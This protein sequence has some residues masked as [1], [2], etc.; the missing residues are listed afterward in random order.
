VDYGSFSIFSTLFV[1]WVVKKIDWR[2][3]VT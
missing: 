1:G 2:V 3:P